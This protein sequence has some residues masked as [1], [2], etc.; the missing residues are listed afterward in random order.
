M[1][2]GP[3]TSIESEEF[4]AKR[5]DPGQLGDL[6]QTDVLG[7]GS[8]APTVIGVGE[9]TGRRELGADAGKAAWRRRLAPRHRQAVGTFFGG[10]EPDRR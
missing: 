5:L 3:E 9:A 6:D 4:E 10:S 1:H 2:Y 7:I 8:T